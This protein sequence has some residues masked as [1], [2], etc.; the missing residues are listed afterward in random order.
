MGRITPIYRSN[1]IAHNEARD[2]PPGIKP[3]VVR[4]NNVVQL[5]LPFISLYIRYVKDGIVKPATKRSA[6]DWIPIRK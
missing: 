1:V 6:T 5:L 4:T 2:N 3:M